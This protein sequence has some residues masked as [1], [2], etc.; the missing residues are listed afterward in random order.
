MA[1]DAEQFGEHH[2]DHVDAIRHGD[3]GQFFYG[4][5]V[6]HLVDAAAK[7]FDTVGVRDVAVPG[8]ALAH[9]LGA[10][11]VV[12]D[13]RHAVDDLFA[14]QL[15]NNAEGTVRGRVVR[16]EVEEHEVLVVG[17][18]FHAPLF[19]FESQRFH[20]QILFG[21]GQ[22]KRIE[23]GGARRV[24]F[25]QRVAF[26]GRRHHDATQIWVA[27]E[28]NTKHFPGFTFIPVGV[29]EQFGEGWQMQIVFRQRHLEHDVAVA[30]DGNQVIEN[31]KIRGGQAIAVRAQT[32]VHTVQV[33]Q[34]H[35]RLRQFLQEITHLK[36]L[37][38]LDP[39]HRY[40]G[41]G[42]LNGK[43]IR[44]KA[45]AQFA[46]HRVIKVIAGLPGWCGVMRG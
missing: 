16:T 32:F 43:G 14:I 18:A 46:D 7:V 11:V 15:Q 3:P 6:R 1:V 17:A 20:L 44:P 22:L 13:I 25:T 19:R 2:A 5:H 24:V 26:P 40:A 23:F 12:T 41:A 34:H 9:L 39:Y 27:I 29:G 36:Q 45:V 8:L 30:V 42:W 38:A 35:V 37:L 4:Q 10:A 21:F 33:K 28:G 31:G